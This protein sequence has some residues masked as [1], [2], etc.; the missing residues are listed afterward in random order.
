M[1]RRTPDFDVALSF[2]G[3]DRGYVEQ[4]ARNLATMDLRVFYDKHEA[5][6]LWGKDLYSHLSQIYS[7]RARFT[8]MFI[9]KHYKNKLWTNHER[10]SAQARAFRERREYILPVRFDSTKIPG[11]LDTVGYLSLENVSPAQL[12]NL[13]R[14]KLGPIERPG[15]FPSRPTALW[16][17]LKARRPTERDRA[18]NVAIRLFQAMKLMTPRERFLFGTAVIHGCQ[19]KLPKNVHIELGY[20]SRLTRASREEIVA[21]FSR[22]ECLG[23]TAYVKKPPRNGHHL[24]EGEQLELSYFSGLK[25]RTNY[26]NKVLAAAFNCFT[27]ESCTEC[28]KLAVRKLDWSLLASPPSNSSLHRTRTRDSGRPKR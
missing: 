1:S 22:L 28:V 24:G 23:V 4:V 26:E 9:S 25:V 21:A 18:T 17:T 15:Y 6:T 27:S 7:D 16:K 2:A 20:L 14:E 3:E 5:V 12:A 19:E 11:V 10:A 8:V 13:I